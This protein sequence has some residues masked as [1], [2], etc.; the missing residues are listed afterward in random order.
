MVSI[1]E[2]TH[3]AIISVSSSG[4]LFAWNSA[5]AHLF[6]IRK[7]HQ[8]TSLYELPAFSEFPG[9]DSTASADGDSDQNIVF[10]SRSSD[11]VIHYYSVQ[12][13]RMYDQPRRQHRVALFFRDVTSERLRSHFLSIESNT[14]NFIHEDGPDDV[15]IQLIQMICEDL[16]WKIGELWYPESGQERLYLKNFWHGLK[17][18]YI[19]FEKKSES[20]VFGKGVGLP[21]I[22]W[23]R[24][25]AIWFEDVTENSSF[26]RQDLARK[27]GLKSAV[28]I[29]IVYSGGTK[30]VLTLFNEERI[31][32]S[33]S[34]LNDLSLLGVQ[35]G[36]V[37]RQVEMEVSERKTRALFQTMA[38][39]SPIGLF[40]TDASGLCRYVNPTYE[41]ITGQTSAMATGE[42]WVN[43]IHPDDR[44]KVIEGW[45]A[46]VQSKDPYSGVH[47]LFHSSEELRWVSVSA[48]PVETG[49][50]IDGYVGTV[51]DIT[52]QRRK[53]EELQ[54]YSLNLS[55]M[56]EERTREIEDLQEEIIAQAKDKEDLR[57]AAEIQEN[58]LPKD[59][60]SVDGFD[61]ACRMLTARYVSGDFYYLDVPDPS[62]LHV[63]IADISGKGISAAILSASTRTLL[64]SR[65]VELN[66]PQDALKKIN[67][68]QYADFDKAHRFVTMAVA[69]FDERDGLFSYASAGH[70]ETLIFRCKDSTVETLP[71][72]SMP[73]GIFPEIDGADLHYQLR[74]GDITLFYSDGVTEA[75][76]PQEEF[77]G[78][79]RLTILLKA[80]GKGKSD[81]NTIAEDIVRTVDRF[82]AMQYPK[83]DVTVI[84]IRAS[85]R[86]VSLEKTAELDNLDEMVLWIRSHAVP[87][88][89]ELASSIELVSSELLTNIIRHSYV[90]PD[91]NSD[92]T[93][94]FIRIELSLNLDDI[95]IDLYDSGK[96]FDFSDVPDPDLETASEGGYGLWIVKELSDSVQYSRENN[97]T[98]NHWSILKYSPRGGGEHE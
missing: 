55:A 54:Q 95:V 24:E 70:T 34:L 16:D 30:C 72:T 98:V 69:R 35:I 32:P 17:Q 58:L 78:I 88:G 46:S 26:V 47:R 20:T 53:D 12:F 79:D 93:P 27:A 76:N 66:S 39:S 81:A 45:L 23:T 84:V 68:F 29:P 40:V 19:D 50:E 4:D 97:D 51:Q 31:S 44:D 37:I 9:L 77:F 96:A 15:L 90:G 91:S 82:S 89:E 28:G 18:E 49:N 64:N 5:A 13:L 22:A 25:R 60:P 14:V 75:E 59:T 61:I 80:H 73:V 63:V 43:G 56:V 7:E 3:E 42:G 92:E 83:D 6:D 94:R 87:Y 2:S 67:R 71:S 36:Q 10:R 52:E 33:E 62:H 86:K 85:S 38:E 74:P 8:N 1:L 11:G 48:A 65:V 21:G 57:L 41:D